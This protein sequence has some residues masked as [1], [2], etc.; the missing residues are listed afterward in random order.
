MGVAKKGKPMPPAINVNDYATKTKL[1]NVCG[2]RHT[3]VVE[4]QAVDDA[5]LYTDLQPVPE[6][7]RSSC[8][9]SSEPSAGETSSRFGSYTVCLSLFSDPEGRKTGLYANDSSTFDQ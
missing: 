6:D 7:D 9:R 3:P 1:N 2:S 8:G 4:K 5:V